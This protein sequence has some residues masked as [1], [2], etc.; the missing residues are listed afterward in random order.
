[1]TL[2][3][4]I[5]QLYGVWVG[6][7]SEG[8]EVAPHQHDMENVV[9]LDELLPN[10]LGQLTRPFGTAPVEPGVGA[11]S[12][13]RTQQRI[14]ES[15]R[16]GIPAVAHEECLAGFAAWRATA[17]PVPLSWGASFHP[18]LIEEMAGRIGADMRSVGVHQGLAPVL[19]VVRDARWGRVEETIGEDPYLVSVLG[20][21]YVRG[22]ESAC[23][24][25]TLKHF[26]GYS[27]SRAGRNLAP[28]SAG[29][30]EIADVFLPPF[31]MA[32]RAGARSV[33][34]SYTDIDGVPAAGDPALLTT[35]L[36]ETYGFTGRSEEHTSEL[37][38]RQ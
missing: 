15:S 26:V 8:G 19:D 24:V 7:S 36:R 35:L 16:L 38:S 3:E 31:E 9:D 23:I 13:L 37:Q 30:R 34:N 17:Y 27:A 28:V 22:L 32:L 14:V 11:L 1:M 33:M 12:L 25:A 18:E 29:P 4:K 21:A 20:S 10:G 6:A 2:D 5:A